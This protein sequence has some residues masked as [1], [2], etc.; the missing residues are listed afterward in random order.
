M[1]YQAVLASFLERRSGLIG[2]CRHI[3]PFEN[4][5][6]FLRLAELDVHLHP[7]PSEF[8]YQ[9]KTKKRSHI[10]NCNSCLRY[11]CD[12]KRNIDGYTYIGVFAFVLEL[13]QTCDALRHVFQVSGKLGSS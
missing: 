2:K 5:I 9:L 8:L 6:I 10:C 7:P 1:A 4:L 12:T 3:S 11:R 13:V